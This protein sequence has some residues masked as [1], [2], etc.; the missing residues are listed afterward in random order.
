MMNVVF[1]KIRIIIVGLEIFVIV[2]VVDVDDVGIIILLFLLD[3]SRLLVLKLNMLFCSVFNERV[4]M[5]MVLVNVFVN[6]SL[7]LFKF[8]LL[9][10][11]DV[12]LVI[13]N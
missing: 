8:V 7:R 5:L 2:N 9:F 12:N 11:F 10:E 3:N 13:L 4:K 6:D 1:I